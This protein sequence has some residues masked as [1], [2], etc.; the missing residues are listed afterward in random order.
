MVFDWLRFNRQR[1][2]HAGTIAQLKEQL[3][4][5]R[6]DPRLNLQLA[7]VLIQAQRPQEA[8]PLLEAVADDFALQGMGA[9]AIAVFKRLQ[10]LRP[11]HADVEEKLA[12]LISQQE[13]P[14]PDPWRQKAA[15]RKAEVEIGM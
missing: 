3:K 12:Y 7:E 14:S 10:A 5:R 9:R 1:R 11:G 6:G 2:E 15:E 13:N 8:A 4:K